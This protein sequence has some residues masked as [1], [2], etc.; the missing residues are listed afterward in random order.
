VD[1]GFGKTKVNE[2]MIMKRIMFIIGFITFAAL[3]AAV[4]AAHPQILVN[5]SDRDAVCRKLQDGWA[6]EAYK[7][8]KDSVDPYIKRCKEDPNW[9]TS[10]L[11]MNWQGHYTTDI[12][13][14]SCWVGGK[15][16]APVPTPRFAGARDWAT[17]YKMPAEIENFKP[18]NDNNGKVWLLNGETKQEE[19][20]DPQTT[21]RILE[22]TN[23][24]IVTLASQAAFIYWIEGDPAYARMASDV[25]WT[26]MHGFSFKTP[27]QVPADDKNMVKIIGMT[28]FE[29][30]HEDIVTPLSLSYDFL[31]DYLQKEGSDVR[32]IQAGLKRMIDRVIDGGSSEGNWNLNQA[33][34]IAFGGL[35]LEDNADYTDG[36]GR[37]YYTDVVLNAKLP[38]Q[39]GLSLVI[40]QGYDAKT[41][42]WPEAPG[43]GFG[44]TADIVRMALLTG[45]QP[46]GQKV[47]ASSILPR[48]A[49]A[50]LDLLYP[51]GWSCGVGDT[52]NTR[53]NTVA[54]ELLIASARKH[55]DSDTEMRLTAALQREI[56]TGFYDR[57]KQSNLLA[58]TQYV[59][60]LKP[61]AKAPQA[62]RTSWAAPL[63]I[64]IQ[65][66][67]DSKYALAAAMF[68]TDGGHIHA[69]GLAME[70]YGTG[71]IL[72][73][74]PGRGVSYWQ[75]E[76]GDYYSQPP[77]HNTVIVNGSTTYPAYGKD[78]IVMQ[79][80]YA[81]P[82][83]GQSGISPNIGFA[84]GS[85]QYTKPAAQ[86]QRTLALIRTGPKSGF[87]FDV[88]RSRAKSDSFHD[89]LYHNI[90][91]SMVMLDSAAKAV[92][93]SPSDRLGTKHGNLKGYDY[94]KNERLADYEGDWQAVFIAAMPDGTKHL[95]SL[96][97][98]GQRDR[99]IFAVDAP[100]NHAARGVLPQ[101]YTEM[102]MPTVLVRQAGDAWN[103][104]FIAVYE[105]Y[106]D[107]DG[108]MIRSVQADDKLK[109]N[110]SL[111]ACVVTCKDGLRVYLMQ[112]DKGT[113]MRQIN[114]FGCHGRFGVV[115]IR[116]RG[117]EELYLGNGQKIGDRDIW[118]ASADGLA[119]DASL[120]R[121]DDGWSYSASG[122]IKVSF[123]T[124]I[125]PA[126]KNQRI[127]ED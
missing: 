35:S 125:L 67:G 59:D 33:R 76:H 38:N 127:P 56:D 5:T 30:I 81:E 57:S 100:A 88:F 115:F 123:V 87:Y 120:I 8:L 84:Q 98:P 36:K 121:D 70:L 9:L 108:P 34:I 37:P 89:Y 119:I 105:P 42:L 39:T 41:A 3:H 10:R 48:A 68:A 49:L 46:A 114:G 31:H 54:L 96:W 117:I 58:L 112:D 122:P 124:R 40:E 51:D 2:K 86:Q 16:Q 25:L 78:R 69:N 13:E 15:G 47:L 64:L 52:V 12:C 106:L 55:N 111:A 109:G 29:V 118:I 101:A 60:Q 7:N 116:D 104:P 85:V 92:P 6:K 53:I 91:Q 72:G 22:T 74:D 103:R 26:Y 65:R 63:N 71:I 66:N 20:T 11:M 75:A 27:P 45:S 19:W 95:M 61:S 18:Y 83:D 24:R 126:G 62:A 110:S 32:L 90:G 99:R 113:Q 23:D 80:D 4:Y 28:S 97:M 102:P 82:K 21:G 14:K 1:C 94:F 50:Q 93:L 44:T 107:S 17:K 77:A 79:L 73:A 43:Y